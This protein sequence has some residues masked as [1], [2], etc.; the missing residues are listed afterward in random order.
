[1]TVE[2]RD[3][4]R[5]RLLGQRAGEQGQS[6]EQ[7]GRRVVEAAGRDL[8]DDPGV[9]LRPAEG[10]HD[11]APPSGF[12]G[13]SPSGAP[14]P[15]QLSRLTRPRSSPD[16]VVEVAT[17]AVCRCFSALKVSTATGAGRPLASPNGPDSYM[18]GPSSKSSEQPI[19]SS[20]W[21][22]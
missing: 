9:R 19:S 16:A 2:P 17:S 3:L 12:V 4:R 21:A 8:V 14:L 20:S 10:P 1:Q 13:K 5:I 15:S 11:G 7:R 18:P 22:R 6:L